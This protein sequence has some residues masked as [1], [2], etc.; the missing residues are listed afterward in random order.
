MTMSLLRHKFVLFIYWTVQIQYIMYAVNL[1]TQQHSCT[2]T[3]YHILYSLYSVYLRSI[4]KTK[5]EASYHIYTSLRPVINVKAS[6]C[7]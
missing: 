4:I 7:V 1:Q 6:F 2:R 3:K 5:L